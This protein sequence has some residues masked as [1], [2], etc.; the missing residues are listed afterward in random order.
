MDGLHRKKSV[1]VPLKQEE[2]VL[3]VLSW[4]CSLER[5]SVNRAAA[6]PV[7]LRPGED[8]NNRWWGGLLLSLVLAPYL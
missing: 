4:W 8:E 6:L 3:S 2:Y 7:V 5:C 1:C